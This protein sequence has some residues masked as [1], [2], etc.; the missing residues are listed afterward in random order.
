MK[1]TFDSFSY[2]FFVIVGSEDD[3][4]GWVQSHVE[5]I[6]LKLLCIFLISLN[7]LLP[8]SMTY[9]KQ[10]LPVKNRKSGSSSGFIADKNPF[11]NTETRRCN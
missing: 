3:R 11:L 7:D 2:E 8:I 9:L 5:I 6:D 10:D 1:H 4:D